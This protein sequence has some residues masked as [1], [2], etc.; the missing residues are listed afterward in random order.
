MMESQA[1]RWKLFSVSVGSDVVCEE[2]GMSFSVG[3]V[4]ELIRSSRKLVMDH[5]QRYLEKYTSL[6]AVNASFENEAI[7][8]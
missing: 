2:E 8:Y 4:K 3:N 5:C 6:S 1:L 7:D